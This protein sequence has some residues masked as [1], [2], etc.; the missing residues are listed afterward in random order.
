M[1]KIVPYLWFDKK[2]KEAV[3]FYTSVFKKAEIGN[4]THYDIASSKVSGQTEGSVMTVEFSLFG[5]SFA[6]LNGGPDFKFSQAI[7]FLINC[8]TQ[9]EVDYYWEKLGQGGEHQVCGW[10]KDKFGVTWQVVPTI[11]DKLLQDPDPIKAG[12][13]MEAML[14]MK[15]IDIEKLKQAY[16]QNSE[17]I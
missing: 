10:L 9:E 13:V 4:I 11:L 12:K 14:Q 3:D 5:Q 8:E 7:S 1:Q 17:K 15:K 6:A 16:N 2:A